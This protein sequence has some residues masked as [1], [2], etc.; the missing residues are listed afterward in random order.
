LELNNIKNGI[1]K[2]I[3][4]SKITN[5]T[6]SNTKTK[7]LLIRESHVRRQQVKKFRKQN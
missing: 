2:R 6:P 5:G 7:Q 3:K 4:N 1:L